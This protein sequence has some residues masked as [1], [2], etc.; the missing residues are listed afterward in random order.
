MPIRVALQ[1]GVIAFAA[2]A[3]CQGRLARAADP[4]ERVTFQSADG[5]TTLVGYLFMPDA[6]PAPRR[7]PS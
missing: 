5:K 4:P 3:Y 7:R 2:L 1:A 6:R